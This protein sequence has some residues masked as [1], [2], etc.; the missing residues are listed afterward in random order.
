MRDKFAI[1]EEVWTLLEQA[2]VVRGR[3]VHDKIPD[4]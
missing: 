3:T 4:F 2:R 1:R